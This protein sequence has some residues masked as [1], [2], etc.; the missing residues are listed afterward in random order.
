MANSYCITDLWM[1]GTGI[2]HPAQSRVIPYYQ[3][4]FAL[5]SEQAFAALCP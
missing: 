2:P 4:R 1:H 3:S 5:G